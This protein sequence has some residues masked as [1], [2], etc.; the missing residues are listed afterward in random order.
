M[1]LKAFVLAYVQSN[2]HNIPVY[3]FLPAKPG[4]TH[5]PSSN[6]KVASATIISAVDN[7]AQLL[8]MEDLQHVDV[9]L[10]SPADSRAFELRWALA[11]EPSSIRQ[12]PPAPPAQAA[13]P[14]AATSPIQSLTVNAQGA[15][16]SP[17]VGQPQQLPS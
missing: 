11:L 7:N 9:E 12:K 10:L 4:T 8:R 17:Q 16:L 14:S 13:V 6:G 2:N 5:I 1:K 15:P 3:S